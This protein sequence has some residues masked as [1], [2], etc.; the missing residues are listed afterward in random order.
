MG[1]V[2]QS[3]KDFILDEFL[4]GEDP[5]ELTAS[6]PLISSGILDSLAT[7]KLSQF[8]EQHFDIQMAAHEL[9]EEHIGT[10]AAIEQLIASKQ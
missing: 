6:T 4:R 10:I 2:G 9:D 1:P 5:D 8:L 7:L 3:V